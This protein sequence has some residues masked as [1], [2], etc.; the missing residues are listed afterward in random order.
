M[1]TTS[2]ST[3]IRKGLVE[4][5]QHLD[6]W[7]EA[8]PA[9]EQQFVLGPDGLP[10]L[11]THI[12]VIDTST[13]KIEEGTLG[14]CQVCHGQVDD[15]LLQMDY[16][17]CVCLDH[18]SPEERRQ[19]ENELELSQIVQRALLPQTIPFIDGLEL[20]AFS[21]PAQIVGGDYFDF[22]QF[23]DGAHGLAM[24]DV[25]GHGVSAGMLMTSLQTAF[26]TLVP[27]ALGPAEVL[28]RIN[29]LYVHNIN[30]TTFVTAFFA[31]LDIRARTLTYASAGHN[32]ALLYRS[33][34][35]D[36]QQLGPT[37]AAIGLIEGAPLGSKHV[38][39]GSG[40]RLLLYTDGITEAINADRQPFGMQ[41]LADV[42]R[43]NHGLSPDGLVRA[44]R[45]DLD[46]FTGGQPL[47]DDTTLVAVAF[48]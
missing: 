41:R 25:S 31:R 19:L 20:A 5:R 18:F 2:V 1:T 36:V 15:E 29:R 37:G 30:F 40:D 21:R 7:R 24:A 27:E 22:L 4:K 8:A 16:T 34:E 46:A 45:D 26:H 28:E 48:R 10:A 47:A 43:S 44:I 14:I 13:E 33:S 42:I 23:K 9:E 11:E 17:A 38:P 35:G 32:P 12:H 6:E 39:L 3:D